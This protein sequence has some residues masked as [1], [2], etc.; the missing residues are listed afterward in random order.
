M[1]ESY[2]GA[3]RSFVAVFIVYKV[4]RTVQMGASVI[5]QCES[6]KGH[7]SALSA[8]SQTSP[9]SYPGL[10]SPYPKGSAGK[11]AHPS[12]P[13]QR[14]ATEKKTSRSFHDFCAPTEITQLIHFK[15]GKTETGIFHFFQSSG[16]L[17]KTCQ[18]KYTPKFRIFPFPFAT[19]G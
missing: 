19:I 11:S 18:R 12:R 7:R 5:L 6:Q 1:N 9:I 14:T 17:E 15:T 3:V 4:N 2:H 8:L 13:H 10:S 16:R